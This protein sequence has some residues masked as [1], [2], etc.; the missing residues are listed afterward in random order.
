MC[1][2]R[3]PFFPTWAAASQDVYA[4]H[5]STGWTHVKLLISLAGGKP[6]STT[7]PSEA[8]NH[9]PALACETKTKPAC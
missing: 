7:A 3:C 4:C 5:W 8:T 6:K 1:C 2:T 9:I